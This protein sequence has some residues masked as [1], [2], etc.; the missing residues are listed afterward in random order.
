EIALRVMR[1]AI[2]MGITTVAVFSEA[3]RQALHV[4][5]A[6]EAVFIGPPA[7]SESYLK[8]ERIIEAA[9]RTGADAVHPGYG[10]LSE[11]ASFA[12]A[13]EKAGLIFIGPSASAI[14][15]M[16]SKLAAKAAVAKFDVPLVPGTSEPISDI[17]EAKRV[18]AKIGYPILIKASA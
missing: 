17:E 18:A 13:C 15:L 1:S 16:G 9:K 10:F 6:D 2:E 3:D 4:R 11:N 8:I 14:N 7:S 12:A 5:Y